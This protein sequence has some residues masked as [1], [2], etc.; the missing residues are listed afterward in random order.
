[1]KKAF[2]AQ[3]K[4]TQLCECNR[5]NQVNAVLSQCCYQFKVDENE[6]KPQMFSIFFSHTIQNEHCLF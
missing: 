6:K 1:M 3:I 5:R 2:D 4:C